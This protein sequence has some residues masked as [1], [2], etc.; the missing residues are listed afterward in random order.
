MVSDGNGKSGSLRKVRLKTP[1]T[2]EDLAGLR[3]GDIVY[4]DG[5]VYTG[6]EGVY[7]RAIAEGIKPPVDLRSLTNV[8]FH[9][10]PAASVNADGSFNIGAVTATASF[11]FAKYLT[12]WFERASFEFHGNNPDPYRVLLGRLGDDLAGRRNWR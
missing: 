3:L 11:R 5:V 4:L 2:D 12:Q 1:V 7:H 9:C 8:T 10:S 6:R